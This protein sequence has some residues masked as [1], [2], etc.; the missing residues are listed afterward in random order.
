LILLYFY[1]CLSFKKSIIWYPQ[2][3]TI[4]GWI[5]KIYV[6]DDLTCLVCFQPPP[7]PIKPTD[8]QLSLAD[9]DI[10][11]VVGK[12]NGGMVQLVQHKWTNQFFALK[13]I[14]LLLIVNSHIL[15]SHFFLIY[16]FVL[17]LSTHTPYL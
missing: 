6:M 4:V 16:A 3:P 8:D 17:V 10:V 1:K 14:Y 9:I 13:V 11:K 7:N 2:T 12:G 5:L 15:L